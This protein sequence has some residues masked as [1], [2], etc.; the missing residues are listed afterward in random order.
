MPS[1]GDLIH[2][3]RIGD[4]LGAGGMGQVFLATD[5]RLG[6]QVALK[7]LPP[8]RADDQE[9]R[10]RLLKEARAAA[11]LRSPHVA[12]TYDIGEHE[13]SLF[14][15]MEYVEGTLVSDTL[16]EGPLSVSNALDLATQVADALE[17]AH[18]YGVVHRDIKSANI[19]VTARGLARV[20][21]FGLAKFMP[22]APS[23]PTDVTRLQE[24]SPGLV[25][26]T[27]SYM[28]PEQVLARTI[29]HRS[30]LFSLGVVLF[31]MVAGRLPFQGESVTE[32]ADAI[33]HGEPPAVARFNY[34]APVELD[35]VLRKA[36]H[37]NPDYRYQSARELFIDLHAV[38]ESR[39]SSERPAATTGDA[40]GS[41]E[42]ETSDTPHDPTIAVMAFSNITGESVDDWIGSGIAETVTTDLKAVQ[43]L[44]IISRAQ[45]IDMLKN[46]SRDEGTAYD[47][48][49]AADVGRR[50]G[51]TW[52]IG[53][54]Y[55]RL[56][57]QIRIT[58]HLVDVDTGTLSR[59]VKI[60]GR[61]D[62]IFELQDKLVYDL[63]QSLNVTLD[64]S[65]VARIGRSE[66]DSVEA[67]EAYSRGLANLRL[68]DI[69]SVD[70]AIHL[71]ERAT[72]HDPGYAAAWALLGNAYDLKSGFLSLPE[73][74]EKAVRLE[75][76]AL[77]LD[78]NSANAQRWLGS[79]YLTLGRY[80]EAI[81][82]I[83][84]ALRLDPDHA[85]AHAGLARAKWMGQGKIRE[86]IRLFQRALQINPDQGYSYLQLAF[87]YAINREYEKGIQVARDA[88]ALQEQDSSGREGLQIVGAHNRLGYLYYRQGR[89]DEA[90]AEY[91]RELAFLGSHDHALA[92]R[93]SIELYQKLA[94]AYIAKGQRD[95][96]RRYVQ[97]AVKGF[98]RRIAKGA[99]DPFTKYYIAALYALEGNRDKALRYLEESS[100]QLAAINRVRAQT[101]PDFDSIRDEPRFLAVVGAPG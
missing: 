29:D 96:A 48:Q 100:Q 18:S 81:E 3:Y 77:E 68:G 69:A 57:Q 32:V 15:V 33:L 6:R 38:A 14:I 82:A 20:L 78:P 58:A 66:T 60:D 52:T 27:I 98:E 36:L 84:E 17:E 87:L 49:L 67:Y 94:A 91:E 86:A 45:I 5:E 16:A 88:V 24:T 70:R 35:V 37:K 72:E 59:T 46:L 90:I 50:L 74:A 75:Q 53:G 51:A 54:A 89:H 7:F 43:G 80:D 64:Q 76:R 71:L 39:A 8:A 93:T 65:E 99:D 9:S 10:G 25:M 42:P 56:G 41:T 11:L 23:E 95:D 40:S 62:D 63:S 61:I 22:G 28:S 92:E 1:P 30:D 73:L 85:N 47:D 44:Q 83:T 19:M 12:V 34:E 79:A 101:D 21:D 26:G 4:Q 2:H 31:E 97:L 13:G 55:Q